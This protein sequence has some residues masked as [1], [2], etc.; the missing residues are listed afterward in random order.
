MKKNNRLKI[1][2]LGILLIFVA[3]FCVTNYQVPVELDEVEEVNRTEKSSSWNVTASFVEGDII[4][5]LVLEPQYQIPGWLQC[6][7]PA[8]Y[9]LPYGYCK[10]PHIFV[11]LDL[12]KDDELVS[13]VEMV[14]VNDPYAKEPINMHLYVYNMSYV[15]KNSTMVYHPVETVSGTWVVL[16][17]EGAPANGTYRLEVSASGAIPPPVNNP[18]TKIALGKRLISYPY[19]YLL[20]LGVVSASSGVVCIV[21]G[22]FP[23][24]IERKQ[25]KP[26]R[27]RR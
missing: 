26:K 2:A 6:L 25:K 21:I 23:R 27:S 16:T 22:G 18:P 4:C 10:Y 12:Y 5:G 1:G 13:K 3:Y 7:E 14:W 9:I 20:P 17:P 24:I 19:T 11:Y 15:E 8:G